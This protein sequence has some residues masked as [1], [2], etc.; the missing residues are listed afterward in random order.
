MPFQIISVKPCVPSDNEVENV[1]IFRF[2]VKAQNSVSNNRMSFI[3]L[4]GQRCSWIQ[5]F[6]GLVG[7]SLFQSREIDAHV[8]VHIDFEWGRSCELFALVLKI[9]IEEQKEVLQ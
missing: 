7:Q 1:V 9:P 3:P 6:N 2:E 8:R 5:E 4:Q